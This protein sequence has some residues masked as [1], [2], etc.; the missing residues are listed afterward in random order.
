MPK[1][2][3]QELAQ[4]ARERIARIRHSLTTLEYLCSGTL[5][6]RMKTCGKPACLC[7]QDPAA[8]H[9]PYYEWGYM[10]GGK[11]VH[12]LVSPE[13]A[14]TLRH[15]IANYRKVRKLLRAWQTETQRLID[16]ESPRNR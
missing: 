13:Q 12:R 10:Q 1:R 11:L 14:K 4:Q 7:A 3:P 8:R 5:L 16:A 6:A 2:S 15:A 9:G